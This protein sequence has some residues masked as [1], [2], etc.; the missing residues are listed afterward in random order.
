MFNISSFLD[1]F[2][3][4]INSEETNIKKICEVILNETSIVCN[5]KSIKFQNGVLYLDLSPIQKNKIF[6]NKEA[7]LQSIASFMN[8]KDIR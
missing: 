8:I 6:I 7:I 2:S 1:K 3:K 5:P 4:N